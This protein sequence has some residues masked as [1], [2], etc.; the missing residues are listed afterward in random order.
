MLELEN[1]S[2]IFN[3]GTSLEKVA[4]EN[5]SVKVNDGD[6]ITMLGSNGAGKSTLFNVITGA[7]KVDHGKIL[8]DGDDITATKEHVRARYIGRL[9][10]NPE[11]GTAPHLTVEENLALAYSA[12]KYGKLSFA[13]HKQDREFFQEK[14]RQLDMGLEDRLKT[15]IGLLSGGQ[16][17]AVALMMAVLNPPKILLLDEHTAALDPK[18]AQKILEITN[19]L[20]HKEQMTALMIT[21]NIQDALENGN[22]LFILN[23]G[24]LIQDMDQ[25]EKSR[26]KPADILNYYAV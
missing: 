21:H 13:V 23:E 12:K 9:F 25:K 6:F 19:E 22:R 17:Q 10:Q 20:I 14:L 7:L 18:S 26:L 1:V 8:M 2:V 24:H 5:V 3:K 11:H 15:P 16:R 4:L